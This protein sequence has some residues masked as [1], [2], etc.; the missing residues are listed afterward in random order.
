MGKGP[1]TSTQAFPALFQRY[2]GQIQSQNHSHGQSL[3]Q[4]D[5]AWHSGSHQGPVTIYLALHTVYNTGYFFF[6]LCLALRDSN[7]QASLYSIL[8]IQDDCTPR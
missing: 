1:S 5:A 7:L 8:K 3:S 4:S 6:R 2:N